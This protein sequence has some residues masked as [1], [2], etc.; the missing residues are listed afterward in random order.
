MPNEQA[1]ILKELIEAMV[2][3]EAAHALRAF[4]RLEAAARSGETG[5]DSSLPGVWE[6][7]I[8]LLRRRGY[9]VSTSREIKSALEEIRAVGP[10][11]DLYNLA[12]ALA[13]CDATVSERVGGPTRRRFPALEPFATN[14]AKHEGQKEAPS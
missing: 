10:G 9:F 5:G 12:A 4:S 2:S 11:F 6:S 8:D 3:G 13:H 1:V 7:L 14:G